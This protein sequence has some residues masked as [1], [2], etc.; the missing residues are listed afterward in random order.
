MAM[1]PLRFSSLTRDGLI[2]LYDNYLS[3]SGNL[4]VDGNVDE[5]DLHGEF[6]SQERHY[7]L[8]PINA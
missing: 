7:I 8:P 2:F 1:G 3:Q 4:R 5:D 6:A